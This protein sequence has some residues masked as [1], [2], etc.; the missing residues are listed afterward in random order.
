VAR[1]FGLPVDEVAANEFTAFMRFLLILA[2]SALVLVGCKHP[3]PS[4]DPAAA[5]KPQKAKTGK[6]AVRQSTVPPST[7]QKS[8]PKA[9]ALNELSGKV[10]SVNAALRFAVLD[11]AL[12]QLPAVDQRLGV[13]RQ[14]QKVGEV[15]ITGP[16]RD[17]II[18]ADITAGEAQTG[19]EIRV[20]FWRGQS[21]VLAS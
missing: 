8:M 4:E 12:T 16:A 18:V 2:L 14:G 11:F 3:K 21:I 20:I 6:A 10:A 1:W 5:F 13:Y 17:H 9:T 7:A 15:K 19:A